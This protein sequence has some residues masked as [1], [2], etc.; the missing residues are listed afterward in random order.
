M[1]RAR[2]AFDSSFQSDLLALEVYRDELVLIYPDVDRPLFGAR[3][4]S[5]APLITIDQPLPSLS[6][7]IRADLFPRG[8]TPVLQDLV[9]E[10]TRPARK[11]LARPM[12]LPPQ[13]GWVLFDS[14]ER[15]TPKWFVRLCELR[16]IT[17]SQRGRIC[18]VFNDFVFAV[19]PL[20]G[21]SPRDLFDCID[22]YFPKQRDVPAQAGNVSAFSM[23]HDR[24]DFIQPFPAFPA[25]SI[26]KIERED[27]VD[28]TCAPL[29]LGAWE[30]PKLCRSALIRHG[31]GEDI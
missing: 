22:A 1:N 8:L 11:E 27:P 21:T 2:T 29:V 12:F 24:S 3:I 28:V 17:L 31:L 25:K 13:T 9:A 26:E 16:R 20:D 19:T 6:G 10:R 5:L 15:R 30:P 23:W 18:V 4:H 7:E 14:N